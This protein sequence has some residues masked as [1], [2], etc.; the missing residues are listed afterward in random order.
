MSFQ[1]HTNGHRSQPATTARRF[2]LS[3]TMIMVQIALLVIAGTTLLPDS[4]QAQ[5]AVVAQHTKAYQVSAGPLSEVLGKFAAQA[6]VALSFDPAL[7]AGIHSQ[8]LNGGYSVSAGFATLLTAAGFE[9]VRHND[10][11]YTLKKIPVSE[12]G[13]EKALPTINVA[14]GGNNSN[15]TEGANT[16]ASNA[17]TVGGKT[18]QTLREIPQTV[19][20]ITRQKIE[21]NNLQTLQEVMNTAP[22]ITMFQG[23]MLASRFMSRGFEVGNFRVD[24]GN[25]L[26]GSM[27]GPDWDMAFYD[28]VEVL[29]GADGLFGGASE[30]G[31]TVNFVR[32]KPT[33]ERQI[34]AAIQV[35]SWNFKRAEIDVAGP[36]NASGSLRGRGVLVHE[37]KDFFY[38]IA[39]S[40]RTMAYG[41][42][43][44]DITKDTVA[45]IGM[46][47]SKRDSSYQGY[48]LP[49]SRNGEDLR[50]PRNTYLSGADDWSN[51][52]AYNVFGSVQTKLNS[53][54]ALALNA[55]YEYAKEENFDHYFNGEVDATTGLGLLYSPNHQKPTQYNKS[56][57]LALTGKFSAWGRQHDVVLG[58]GWQKFTATTNF[59]KPINGWTAAGSIYQFNPYDYR[60]TGQS[61]NTGYLTNPIEQSSIYGSV[62]FHVAEPLHIIVGGRLGRYKYDYRNTQFNNAGVVTA[63]S[64][65]SYADNK[66]FTPYIGATY[67][68]NDQWT[69]YG[70]MA[71]TFKSQANFLQSADQ[72]LDPVTGR[73]YELG[74]KGSHLE[75]TLQ[76]LLAVYEIHRDGAAVANGSITTLPNGARCCYRGDGQIVSRGLDLEVSGEVARGLQLTASYNY[77]YN[78]NLKSTASRFETLTPTKLV[79]VFAAYQLPGQLERVKVGGGVHMQSTSYVQDGNLRLN[80]SGYA[81]WNAFADY[82]L[83]DQWSVAVNVNNL[84]DKT[85]YSTIGYAT[86][87]SFYGTPRSVMV[88]LRGKM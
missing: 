44:A 9:A 48:G 78:R 26:A 13:G 36:I 42:L 2:T 25:A 39:T 29:R 72:P 18:V 50:L 6:S 71:E 86:Y 49:F 24:G 76:S 87:G 73:N 74:I 38:D 69:V 28:H 83:N 65:T 84:F 47:Y 32:K 30:P 56:V 70:S 33:R 79:K 77:N 1:R 7:V 22:G 31:G 60:Y 61:A 10:V 85:Y 68:V 57:D 53:N 64:V 75:G 80:Q 59:V 34:Q 8:G 81:I 5:T 27:F 67:D 63:N 4:A 15:V 11:E 21:D 52:D 46:S 66:V 43:E 62:R 37:D 20:V 35:G 54:W 14:A 12:L 40:K 55:N 16:Y 88:S 41:V 17:S 3:P 82:R 58:G 19:T 45:S 23:S 51:K